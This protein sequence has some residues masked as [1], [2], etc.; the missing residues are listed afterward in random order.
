MEIKIWPLAV[1]SGSGTAGR[2]EIGVT[3]ALTLTLSPQERENLAPP[4]AKISGD[5]GQARVRVARHCRPLFPLPGERVRV[6]VSVKPFFTQPHLSLV[7]GKM[8]ETKR[9]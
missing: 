2:E 8:Q 3:L 1:F 5:I 4:P 9:P 6:R 7:I